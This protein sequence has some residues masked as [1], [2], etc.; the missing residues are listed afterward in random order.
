[1]KIE[2]KAKFND[3]AL[4]LDSSFTV[5]FRVKSENK[6]EV[7]TLY[8]QIN[9]M[10][11]NGNNDVK[12]EID[13]F[14]EKRSL[15]ANAYFHLLVNKIAAVQKIG[16][17]ECKILMNLEYGTPATN[18]NGEEIIAKVPASTD[19]SQIYEYSKWIADKKEQSGVETS[20]YLLY[21]RTHTLNKEEMARLIDGVVEVAKENGIETRTPEQIAEM[22]GLWEQER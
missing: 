3:I 10:S 1:M 6:Q 8:E 11:N 18:E 12:L 19:M 2:L 22:I 5:S 16:N 7:E 17:D 9:T 20:Y 14:Q 4:Y 15:N 21:K 13:K